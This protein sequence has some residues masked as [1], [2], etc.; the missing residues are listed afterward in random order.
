M[1]TGTAQ[2]SSD[3]R[4]WRTIIKILFIDIE[5]APGEAFFWGLFD[6]YIPI[7]R[8]ITPGRTLCFAAQWA[9]KKKVMFHSEYHHDRKTMVQKAWELLDEADAV[10]H[11]NGTK[12]DI[13]MLNKEFV[14]AGLAPPSPYAQVDL[15]RVVRRTFRFDS[16]KLDFVLKQLGLDV[17]LSHKGMDLWKGCMAGNPKDWKIMKAYNKQDVNVMPALYERLLPWIEKHPNRALYQ[18]LDGKPTCPNCG[19]KHVQR[20]G[21]ANTRVNLFARFQCMDCGKWARARLS[22][23]VNRKGVLT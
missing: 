4:T 16:N 3:G 2:R 19:S 1:T 10:I 14:L 23:K 21:Y 11:Y 6:K 17:K 20:R 18:D 9:G 22:E 13:P 15:Y 12:F 7:D 8:V 5:T